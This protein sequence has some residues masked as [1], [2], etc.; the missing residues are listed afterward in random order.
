M[1]IRQE[2]T[3][4]ASAEDKPALNWLFDRY[5]YDWQWRFVAHCFHKRYGAQSYQTHR[6]W[7][8]TKEGMIL[9]QNA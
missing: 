2:I 4:H 3:D 5:H 6:V 1:D 7:M 8:P 9:W